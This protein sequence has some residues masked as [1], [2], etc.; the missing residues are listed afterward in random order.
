MEEKT[1]LLSAIECNT[2]AEALL[3]LV[4]QCP[5]QI[6]VKAE[7]D[8]LGASKSLAVFVAGGRSKKPDILGGFSASVNFS[9]AYK[10]QPKTSDQR[11]DRQ[12][13][14]GEI[15]KWLETTEN[16]PLLTDNRKI[17]KITSLGVPYKGEVE[18]DG[19]ITYYADAVME[20]KKE[21]KDPLL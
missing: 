7:Y 18:K 13:I 19:S 10:S 20:Y 14:V 12:E 4:R 11:L 17:T 16:L 1:E 2:V 8:A 3:E 21:E 5:E 15:V 9:V 6:G